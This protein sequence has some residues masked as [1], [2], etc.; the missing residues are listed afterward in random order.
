M[1]R[2]DRR[3]RG[4]GRSVG[5][6]RF[7]FVDLAGSDCER[8]I[9]FAKSRSQ[10]RHQAFLK[11]RQ[12]HSAEP[13]EGESADACLEDRPPNFLVILDLQF[14]L[15]FARRE[16]IDF[17]EESADRGLWRIRIGGANHRAQMFP[18]RLEGSRR[19]EP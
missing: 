3:R 10:S 5:E 12:S 11:T 1:N 14:Q 7:D 13:I 4:N 9:G 2:F 6:T 18:S 19:V 17:E 16:A 8:A 15:G